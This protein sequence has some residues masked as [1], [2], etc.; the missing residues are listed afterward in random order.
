MLLK[1]LPSKKLDMRL[2]INM[3]VALDM[4][5]SE[6]IRSQGTYKI[7][8]ALVSRDKLATRLIMLYAG[9]SISQMDIGILP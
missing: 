1:K 7:M 9:K 3:I 5:M 6:T 8:K 2:Q 4:F